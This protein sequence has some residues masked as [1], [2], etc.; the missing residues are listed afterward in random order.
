MKLVELAQHENWF[1]SAESKVCTGC[2]GHPLEW[3]L[4]GSLCYLGGGITFNDLEE[5]T[6]VSE[7]SPCNFFHQFLQVGYTFCLIDG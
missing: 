7:S 3:T 1:P 6:Y 2:M 5:A 4:L